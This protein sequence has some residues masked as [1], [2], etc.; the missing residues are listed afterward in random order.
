MDRSACVR[1]PRPRVQCGVRRAGS[2]AHVKALMGG[3]F[4]C[5]AP[6][7]MPRALGT[8]GAARQPA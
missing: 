7:A 3:V 8:W 1:P 4:E 6:V 2:G 5:C